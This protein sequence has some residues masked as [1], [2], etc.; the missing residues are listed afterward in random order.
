MHFIR[1]NAKE[2]KQLSLSF[3]QY[4]WA[5]LGSAFYSSLKTIIMTLESLQERMAIL[6]GMIAQ[7]SKLIEMYTEDKRTINE[8]GINTEMDRFVSDS[9]DSC[10]KAMIAFK[11]ELQSQYSAATMAVAMNN[12]TPVERINIMLKMVE[13]IENLENI[14]PKGE[15]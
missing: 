13:D 8:R 12:K 7:T 5:F 6:K 9:V 1:T 10:I 2:I 3:I 4:G 11:R 15:A 14:T